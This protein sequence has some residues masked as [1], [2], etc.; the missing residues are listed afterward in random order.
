MG[1]FRLKFIGNYLLAACSKKKNT[2]IKVFDL[3]SGEHV[4]N[5]KGHRG[6][7]YTMQTTQNEK[8]LVTAG[9]DHI[10]RVASF[11]NYSGQFIDEDE[12]E[13]DIKPRTYISIW[14]KFYNQKPQLVKIG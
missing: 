1:C 3:G 10:V 2:V 14:S 11:P 9:S 5:L 8:I 6:V 4:M 12:S 7:I 13:E